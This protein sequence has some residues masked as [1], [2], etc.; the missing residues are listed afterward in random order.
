MFFMVVQAH[1]THCSCPYLDGLG[2]HGSLIGDGLLGRHDGL[3]LLY[4]DRV[5][6]NALDQRRRLDVRLSQL[7]RQVLEFLLHHR[8]LVRKEGRCV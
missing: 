5:T 2:R 3:D 7:G 4:V 1:K 8:H 6:F